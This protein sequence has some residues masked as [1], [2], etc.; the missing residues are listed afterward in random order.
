ML[1]FTNAPTSF[2]STRLP[3]PPPPVPL[4]QAGAS[5]KREQAPALHKTSP[6]RERPWVIAKQ[7]VFTPFLNRQE[8]Q[9]PQKNFAP[10][11]AFAV[12]SGCIKDKLFGYNAHDRRAGRQSPSTEIYEEPFFLDNL[13]IRV[14]DFPGMSDRKLTVTEAAR[15]FADLVNRTYYRGESTVL[16]RSGEPVAMVV[17]LAG[18]SVTGRDWLAKW[19]ARPRLAA[20]DAD[21]FAAD[22]ARASRNLPF[23]ASPWD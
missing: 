4:R 11:A 15:H 2:P 10:F 16:L 22:L 14:H 20:G 3:T 8:R 19:L 18:A 6:R 23:P 12:F 1:A 17:P 21:A 7:L 9:A 5:A 13:I